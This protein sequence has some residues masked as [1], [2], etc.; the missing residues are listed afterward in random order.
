MKRIVLFFRKRMLLFHFLLSVVSLLLLVFLVSLLLN[1]FTRHNS[2]IEVPDFTG[3]ETEK[4]AQFAEDKGLEYEII[5]SVY[6][7]DKRRGIVIDQDPDPY[8]KVKSG[9]KIYVTVNAKTTEKVLM[10]DLT[11]LSLRQALSTLEASG[12]KAGRLEY[13]PDI[14]ENA[15]LRQKFHGQDIKPGTLIEKGSK[16]NLVLGGGKGTVKIPVPNLI[17]KSRNQA[18]RDLRESS[19]NV[20][21]E[22]FEG[23]KDSLRARV[24][25][26]RPAPGSD[27]TMYMGGVIDLWYAA[28]DHSN[29][30]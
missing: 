29:K 17:G 2:S 12:L 13:V 19:L 15:V 11:D 20:G 22:I 27:N 7:S 30:K 8:T 16:V 26:Q 1:L 5:D 6:D 10:P 21:G 3:V 28:P 25:K 18:L 14:A 23:T 4:I 9:R 24:T